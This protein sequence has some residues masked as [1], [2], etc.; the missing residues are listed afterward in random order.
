[1]RIAQV[2]GL[3]NAENDKNRTKQTYPL[4]WVTKKFPF[5]KQVLLKFVYQCIYRQMLPTHTSDFIF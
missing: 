5:V 4:S 2:C 1:M 3:V